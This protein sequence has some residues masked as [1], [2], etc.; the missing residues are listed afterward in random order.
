MKLDPIESV[1]QDVQRGRPVVI[2]DDK[3]RENEGDLM[4]A[5]ELITPE[6]INF[7]IHDG[8]G[9][10]CVSLTE[11]RLRKL[12]VPVQV[13][14]NTALLGTNFTVSIDHKSVVGRGVTAESRAKT[15]QAMVD[16]DAGPEDFAMPGY[17]FPL[18]AVSGGVLKRSG[19]T[20]GGVDLSRLAG[21]RPAAVICEVMGADGVMLNGAKLENYCR[22]HEL[23]I[24][25]VDTIGNYRL[26]EEVRPRRVVE[27]ELTGLREL[28]FDFS[29]DVAEEMQTSVEPLRVIVYTDDADDTEHI[30]FVK[31][32][33]QN[34]CLVRIH[35]ECLTGDVF[36]SKRCDC[37]WQ[38]EQAMAAICRE[39]SGVV[40]Y[41]HQEGRG[42]GLGNKLRAYDLQDNGLD[43][44]EANIQLGFAPD[45]RSYRVGAHILADLGLTKIRL[46]TNNP[47]KVASLED[48]GI[49]VTERV[50]LRIPPDNCNEAYLQAKRE[51]LGHLF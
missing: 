47:A 13:T 39:G 45:L 27:S 25:S 10:I 32:T 23:K 24:T 19:Q 36:E 33:P 48:F 42:I 29:I 3:D 43:T 37:G 20:E 15:I 44:V 17:V 49:E 30:A 40:V 51:R 14:D 8:K 35:S 1:I 9:L 4:V 2:I 6:S 18:G 22:T 12:G 31:G 28:N 38:F 26:A 5:A 46:L 41:L 50:G 34:G 16:P 7:M 21:L 11:E